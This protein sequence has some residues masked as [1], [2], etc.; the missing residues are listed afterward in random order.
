[1]MD[2]LPYKKW[3]VGQKKNTKSSDTLLSN[4][5]DYVVT[6]INNPQD[7]VITDVETVR[8]RYI[9]TAQLVL[10]NYTSADEKRYIL[11]LDL[12][13]P[14]DLRS[15][16]FLFSRKLRDVCKEI[17]KQRQYGQF[18]PI[19]N[20]L[21]GTS[22]GLDK[23]IYNDVI[24]FISTPSQNIQFGILTPQYFSDNYLLEINELYDVYQNYNNL[25]PSLSTTPYTDTR[26]DTFIS[27]VVPFNTDMFLD[28]QRAILSLSNSFPLYILETKTGKKVKNRQGKYVVA[29]KSIITNGIIDYT[30]IP[31]KFFLYGEQTEEAFIIN[32]YKQLVQQLLQTDFYFLS[33]GYTQISSLL[34]PIVGYFPMKMY[35]THQ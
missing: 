4:Y 2:I 10:L 25:S 20:V 21:R 15:I 7:Q 34:P 35:Y 30:K 9:S 13:N 27:N 23:K 26:F 5:R 19:Q 22:F 18:S 24:E 17:T 31:K 3:E 8:D 6:S 14:D 12:N 16:A 1:M 33:T 32:T 11:N 28:L 29:R